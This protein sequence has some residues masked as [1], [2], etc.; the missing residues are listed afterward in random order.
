MTEINVAAVAAI[1]AIFSAIATALAAWT[2][3][4]GPQRA[5]KIAEKLRSD[6]DAGAER[7][8]TK[9]HVFAVLMANRKSY[10]HAEPVNALNLIDIVFN[11]NR[12]VRSAWAEMY[13]SLCQRIPQHVQEEKL[14]A[15]LSAMARD[16]KLAD[17]LRTDD[18]G[19]VYVPDAIF[20]ERV[21]QMLQR[22]KLLDELKLEDR[23]PSANTA[24][25]ETSSS[26]F[27]PKP[28]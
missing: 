16:L 13:L 14:R 15:L 11:D 28:E 9:L 12:E 10:W 6:G 1:A 25:L 23:S 27:P 22:R 2:A 4:F 21:L 17:E 26:K 7:H 24:G 8:R 18:Y 19:R 3:Y 5:A 20:E